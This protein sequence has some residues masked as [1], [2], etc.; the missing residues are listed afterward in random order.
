MPYF[1]GTIF[2]VDWSSQYYVEVFFRS[3]TGYIHIRVKRLRKLNFTVDGQIMYHEKLCHTVLPRCYTLLTV[4]PPPPPPPPLFS[5]EIG[6]HY[7]P[8]PRGPFKPVCGTAVLA[9]V[10]VLQVQ[11]SCNIV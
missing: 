10:R 3:R 7:T 11:K 8:A 1:L 6:Y 9:R 4:T 5:G 2:L